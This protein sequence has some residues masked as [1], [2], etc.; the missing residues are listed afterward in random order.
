MKLYIYILCFFMAT[1]VLSYPVTIESCGRKV[2]IHQAPKRLITHDINITEIALSLGL[3][4]KIIGVT[5]I[6]GWHKFTP[7]LKQRL[8]PDTV[9][10][11]RK[12]PSLEIILN[13]KPDFVFAGWNYGFTTTNNFNPKRLAH[14]H[15]PSYA[16]KESCVHV[17]AKKHRARMQDL[18]DDIYT[19]G[20]VFG[21]QDTA[22]KLV[23]AYKAEIA[24]LQADIPHT[25]PPK[26]V[27][28]FDNISDTPFTAGAYGMPT[29]LIEAI[30]AKNAMGDLQKSWAKV[31]WEHVA[32]RNPDAYIIVNYGANTA[33]Q[34]INYLKT[35]PAI[36]HTNGIKNNVFIVLEYASVT[37]SPRNIDA[38]RKLKHALYK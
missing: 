22:E 25:H 20:T 1:P 3:S 26:K 34:K 8:H 17:G 30:G 6:S 32:L 31:S 29:A 16:L 2:V 5:G 33:E 15:I 10:L 4:D 38:I 19:L 21:I 12:Y 11:S 36:R 14:F 9:E 24:S 23:S 28:V 13:A 18:Y 27:F 7:E 35:L 37:P